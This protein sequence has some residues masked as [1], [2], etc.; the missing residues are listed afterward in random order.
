M[1]DDF[2]FLW[3]YEKMISDRVLMAEKNETVAVFN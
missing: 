1:E 2:H 3:E